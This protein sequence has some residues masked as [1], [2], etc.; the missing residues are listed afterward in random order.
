MAIDVDVS[1][2]TVCA[3]F[4]DKATLFEAVVAVESARI[5]AAVRRGET[6]T[7]NAKQAE[8]DL[9]SVWVGM[10]PMQH[11]FNELSVITQPDIAARVDHGVEV[12]MQIYGS[13]D[14][15]TDVPKS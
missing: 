3:S 14:R 7:Q 2:M 15:C 4:S 8:K 1:K 6:A 5:D 12:F 13:V 11:R 10:V 9:I